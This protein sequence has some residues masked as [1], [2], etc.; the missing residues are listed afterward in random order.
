MMTILATDLKYNDLHM[1]D[2]ALCGYIKYKDSDRELIPKVE[3]EVKALSMLIEFS[4]IMIDRL[5]ANKKAEMLVDK[6]ELID[7]LKDY[8]LWIGEIITCTAR[9]GTW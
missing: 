5:E 8:D 3:N 6:H 9:G 2:S 7:H 1:L 4:K